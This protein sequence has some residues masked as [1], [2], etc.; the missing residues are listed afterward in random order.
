MSSLTAG[1]KQLILVG[2]GVLLL[3][4]SF[5]LIFQRNMDKASTLEQETAKLNKEIDRLTALQVQV[6]EMQVD[7]PGQ[8]S[9]VNEFTYKFPCRI[10][11]ESELYN[12]YRM[13]VKSGITISSIAPGE[14]QTFIM[15]GKYIPFDGRNYEGVSI[16]VVDQAAEPNSV[17]QDP[18][19]RVPM[20][21]MVG[22]TVGYDLQISGTQKQIFK[23]INWVADNDSPM[24]ITNLSFSFD[25]STGLLSGTMRVYF[26]ALNGNGVTYE[27]PVD[28][29]DFD[30]GTS[31]IF[32]ALKK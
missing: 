4:I 12:V 30:I 6:N 20:N 13:K 1:Q 22:K 32:G 31:S 18:Q 3:I 11:E 25:S 17:E 8:Q 24:S 9:V 2:A 19:S 23:A 28:V 16:P 15:N 10:T 29:D 21:E 27:D 26:H 7:A 5:F 14:H